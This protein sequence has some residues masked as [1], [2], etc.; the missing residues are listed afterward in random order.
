MGPEPNPSHQNPTPP[1][2]LD[3]QS[4]A[5]W[6]P[7]AVALARH[8][9]Y[10]R[11]VRGMRREVHDIVVMKDSLAAEELLALLHEAMLHSYSD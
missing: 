11:E 1:T 2:Y 8:A 6:L 10:S 9:A 4:S 7:D 5:W 3:C